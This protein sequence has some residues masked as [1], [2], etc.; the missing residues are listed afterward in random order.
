MVILLLGVPCLPDLENL[1]L[2]PW[3]GLKRIFIGVIEHLKMTMVE[4]HAVN[5]LGE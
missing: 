5:T 4:T 3:F 2:M 1:H